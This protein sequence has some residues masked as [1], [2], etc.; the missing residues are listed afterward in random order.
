MLAWAHTQTQLGQGRGPHHYG[1]EIVSSTAMVVAGRE[2]RTRVSG[3]SYH[4]PAFMVKL[5]ITQPSEG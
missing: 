2:N 5:D 1:G 3:E 4:Q